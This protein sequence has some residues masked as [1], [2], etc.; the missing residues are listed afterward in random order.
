MIAGLRTPWL[1]DPRRVV[2][3]PM[4]KTAPTLPYFQQWRAARQ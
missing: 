3:L 4:E 1:R 2:L